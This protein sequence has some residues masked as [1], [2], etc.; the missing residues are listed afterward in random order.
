MSEQ[1]KL[2]NGVERGGEW[3]NYSVV[4]PLQCGGLGMLEG[5]NK[6]GAAKLFNLIKNSV[7]CLYTGAGKELPLEK[8]EDFLQLAVIDCWKIGYEQIKLTTK[9]NYP[10]IPENFFCPR[11]SLPGK[12]NYTRV[13]ESWQKLIEE[14]MIDEY[15]AEEP[16]S[17]FWV[18]LPDPIEIESLRNV[19]EGQY[20]EIR[21]R[22]L[23]LG[24]MIRIHKDQRAL[25]SEANMIYACI[26]ACLVEIKGMSAKDF[27]IVKRS[28]GDYF[29]QKH[30]MTVEN[31]EKIQDVTEVNLLG[32]D[33]GDRS[34]IC[35]TCGEE[36][37]GEL[38][39]TN[40]FQLLLRRKSSPVGKKTRKGIS[41]GTIPA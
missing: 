39:H 21:I 3:Y 8:P 5:Q 11:C 6:T 34:I 18:D 23:L 35:K 29:S 14:G 40:F 12:E 28:P 25:E 19:A 4:K 1:F 31:T 24:D 20:H 38:D 27:N 22:Q 30:I 9:D 36:I 41:S 33:P 16:D 15:F 7:D 26:D 32:V 2:Y 13:E 37:G 17:S 10:I